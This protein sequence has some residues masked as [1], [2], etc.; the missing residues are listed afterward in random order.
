MEVKFKICVAIVSFSFCVRNF[1]LSANISRARF[2]Q[3]IQEYTP[4]GFPNL[5]SLLGHSLAITTLKF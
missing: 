2:W 3:N 5:E 1:P 4:F